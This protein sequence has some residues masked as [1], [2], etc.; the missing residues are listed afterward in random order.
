MPDLRGDMRHSGTRCRRQQG[1]RVF[2]REQSLGEIARLVG[3][4][5][6]VLEA[7]ELVEDDQVGL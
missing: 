1:P 5:E 7:L 4:V 2:E 3:A 6:Q